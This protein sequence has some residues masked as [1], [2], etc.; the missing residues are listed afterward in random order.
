MGTRERVVCEYAEV[1][2]VGGDAIGAVVFVY[3]RESYT[4]RRGSIRRH[5]GHTRGGCG[6]G[7]AECWIDV[8]NIAVGDERGITTKRWRGAGEAGGADSRVGDHQV[9]RGTSGCPNI[10]HHYSTA[11]HPS[12]SIPSQF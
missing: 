7:V 9:G 5:T 12:H 3:G 1:L 4:R 11:Q 6:G 8:E 10:V 2:V